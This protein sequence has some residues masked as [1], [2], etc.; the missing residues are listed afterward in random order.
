MYVDY[1]Q[2]ELMLRKP[3]QLLTD[4]PLTAVAAGPGLGTDSAAQ[5]LLAQALRL[6][7]PIVLDADALNLVAA[8]GVLQSAVQARKAP[9]LLT[10]HPAEA[11]RLAGCATADIQADRIVGALLAQGLSAADAL[12]AG[13]YLHGAA[14]DALAA[15]GTGPV[16]LTAGELVDEAR[17]LGNARTDG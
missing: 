15:R 2:P 3:E 9:T 11:A 13:V 6:E 12:I 1:A 17:R 8:Y 14:A 16:G 4:V 7:L 5:R 10:P